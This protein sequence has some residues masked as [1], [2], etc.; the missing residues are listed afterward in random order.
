MSNILDRKLP[1]WAVIAMWIDCRYLYSGCRHYFPP[2]GTNW[3][4]QSPIKNPARRGV[5]KFTR[6]RLIT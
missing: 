6:N 3:A 4:I 1:F 2:K 5:F